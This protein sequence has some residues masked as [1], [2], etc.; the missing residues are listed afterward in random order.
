MLVPFN[1]DLLLCGLLCD[2][3]LWASCPCFRRSRPSQR[4]RTYDDGGRSDLRELAWRFWI[5]QP[6]SKRLIFLRKDMIGCN[7]TKMMKMF[8][9][10]GDNHFLHCASLETSVAANAHL[11][12]G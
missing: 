9:L 12:T 8:S 5:C 11:L 10:I 2:I 7:P 6:T 1:L 4:N 3:P